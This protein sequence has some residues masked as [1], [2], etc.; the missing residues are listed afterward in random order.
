MYDAEMRQGE[1]GAW[2]SA[3]ERLRFKERHLELAA[4][5]LGAMAASRGG[6]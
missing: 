3:C 6:T 5:A 2:A 4:Q 1:V